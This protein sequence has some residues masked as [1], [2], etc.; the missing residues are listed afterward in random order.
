MKWSRGCSK[1]RGGGVTEKDRGG[2][3]VTEKDRGGGSLKRT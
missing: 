3:G 2:G 1:N